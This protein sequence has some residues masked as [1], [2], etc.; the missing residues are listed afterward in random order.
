MLPETCLD[1]RQGNMRM[2]LGSS[3]DELKD[4]GLVYGALDR[5]HCGWKLKR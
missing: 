2:N 3:Q 5:G 4:V 1:D